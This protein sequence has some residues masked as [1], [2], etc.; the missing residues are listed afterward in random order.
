MS[1]GRL[2]TIASPLAWVAFVLGILAL[3]ALDLGLCNRQSR[4]ISP[5]RAAGWTAISVGLSACFGAG[6]A[7]THG[8]PVALEFASGYVLEKALAVDNLFVIARLFSHF[9]VPTQYQHRVLYWGI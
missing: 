3:L 2:S 9:R 7:V 1:D 6:I 5:P 8:S 4:S